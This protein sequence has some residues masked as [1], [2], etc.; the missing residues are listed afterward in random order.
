MD[1]LGVRHHQVV[2]RL[3]PARQRHWL[4]EAAA[5]G[6]E[7][8]WTVARLRAAL[9]SGEDLPP[10]ALVVIVT[11][12]DEKQQQELM[13]RLTSEGYGCKPGQRRERAAVKPA[14]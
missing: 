13:S 8:P 7:N 6:Q 10:T 14:A 9:K 12:K 3:E 1:R 2:A 11:V 5:D 4:S